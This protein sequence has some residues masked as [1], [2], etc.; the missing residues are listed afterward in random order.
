MPSSD[1]GV[2]GVEYFRR[3][4]SSELSEAVV[5]SCDMWMSVQWDVIGF[6]SLQQEE[7]GFDS[8]RS[9]PMATRLGIP[10]SL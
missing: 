7:L 2:Y 9:L 1:D 4:K 5:I 6:T 3:S 10:T 8:A